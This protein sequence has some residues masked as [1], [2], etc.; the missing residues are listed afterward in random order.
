MN[1]MGSRLMVGA[2]LAGLVTGFGGQAG[3]F[4]PDQVH[5]T[6]ISFDGGGGER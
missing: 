6:D 4:G 1:S 3:A 2:A 5:V